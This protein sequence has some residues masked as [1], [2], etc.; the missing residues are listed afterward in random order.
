MIVNFYFK[1]EFVCGTNSN[2]LLKVQD[3]ISLTANFQKDF[4]PNNELGYINIPL[5]LLDFLI[6]YNETYSK[7][8]NIPNEIILNEIIKTANFINYPNISEYLNFYS[9]EQILLFIQQWKNWYFSPYEL[10][11]KNLVIHQCIFENN[12]NSVKSLIMK[13]I[14]NFPVEPL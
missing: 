13:C 5:G 9:D 12:L 7:L 3:K 1:N 6:D 8:N 14:L 10:M 11:T 4:I 2:I